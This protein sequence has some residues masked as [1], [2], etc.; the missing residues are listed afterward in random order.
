MSDVI[1]N[2]PRRGGAELTGSTLRALGLM[3]P[4]ERLGNENISYTSGLDEAEA[5]VARNQPISRESL[6]PEPK[7]PTES[8]VD[9]R[10]AA[11]L[12]GMGKAKAAK[13]TAKDRYIKSLTKHKEA[14]TEA[15][16]DR[17]KQEQGKKI[18]VF[19][20]RLL[21]YSGAPTDINEIQKL[22]QGFKGA[23]KELQDIEDDTLA[24][25]VAKSSLDLEEEKNLAELNLKLDALALKAAE[26]GIQPKELDAL[27]KFVRDN[28]NLAR[29]SL[30][31]KAIPAA[32]R[33]LIR[34]FLDALPPPATVGVTASDRESALKQQ[35]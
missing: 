29:A 31:N 30:S 23:G 24:A 15:L 6:F 9:P 11:M 8:N 25:K 14:Q 4:D 26:Y 13:D 33:S 3:E 7:K 22:S 18:Q 21:A 27:G 32:Q 35:T 16:D 10:V 1:F 2:A 28:E 19:A 20:D 17:I 34:D 12:A 5:I